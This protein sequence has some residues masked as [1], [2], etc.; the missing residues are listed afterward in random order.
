MFCRRQAD[1]LLWQQL[2]TL[3]ADCVDGETLESTAGTKNSAEPWSTDACCWTSGLQHSGGDLMCAL[4]A[5]SSVISAL[6][7]TA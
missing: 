6:D 3:A 4:A 5:E 1:D 2:R 7:L